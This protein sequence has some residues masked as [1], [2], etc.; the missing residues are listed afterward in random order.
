M[1]SLCM[2]LSLAGVMA[3]SNLFADMQITLMDNGDNTPG[4][5]SD[6]SD[7]YSYSNG[8]EFRGV[9]NSGLDSIIDWGAYS[10]TAGTKGTVTTA[11]SGGS[12]GY[13]SGLA[14]SGALFFQTFCTE[15]NEEYTPGGTYT[16]STVGNNA[17]YNNSPTQTPVPITL[18]VA[19]LYSQFAAGK[20]AGY[21]YTYGSGR[22]ATAG[23]LQSAIWILLSE[24]SGTLATWVSND[25]TSGLGSNTSVWTQNANGAYGVEDMTLD[26]PG[27]AQDQL[28]MAVPEAPTVIAGALLLLPFGASAFKILRKQRSV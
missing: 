18:G 1:K 12:W 19:Y 26:N 14:Q 15:L 13:G 28:I 5:H 25:L 27:Q 21:D 22:S 23:D 24:T 11:N 4:P 6:S 2:M 16:I 8:G 7:L 20:L 3:V 10:T 9:G 17:L